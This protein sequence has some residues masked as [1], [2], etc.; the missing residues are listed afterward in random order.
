M[1]LR[2]H[3]H[4]E[5]A[6]EGGVPREGKIGRRP[7]DLPLASRTRLEAHVR[8]GQTEVVKLL[9]V[10]GGE[11]LRRP[12]LT[13]VTGSRG[14][15]LRRVVPA[16]KRKDQN[17][18]AKPARLLENGQGVIRGH[19]KRPGARMPEGM[20]PR[21]AKESGRNKRLTQRARVPYQGPR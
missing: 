17:G 20:R 10:D 9:G 18:L 8:P 15:G 21:K 12:D 4:D 2:G 19:K 1:R 16:R 6:L 5:V 3:P 14:G 13:Q 7:D 11:G